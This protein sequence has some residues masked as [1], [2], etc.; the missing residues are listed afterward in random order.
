MMQASNVYDVKLEQAA[1]RGMA[2]VR[3]RVPA[4][5]VAALFRIYLDQVYAAGRAGTVQLDGQNIFVYRDVETTP[6]HID[7]EFGVG[8]AAPFSSA[9][10]V[11]Y[12]V[13]PSGGVA[14]TTHWGD[15]GALGDAHAAVVTWC[16]SHDVPL[17]GPRWEVYGHWR[18]GI[19]P[20]TDIYYLVAP[21]P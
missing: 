20:R 21:R 6:D 16:R 2:A 1:P 12:S 18:E 19:T 7:V 4:S 10:S 15:Y 13:T 9:G 8:V 17:A 3:A 11:L 14:T 5:R